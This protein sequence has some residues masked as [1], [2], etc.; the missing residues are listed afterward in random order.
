MNF[1]IRTVVH[2]SNVTH[3]PFVLKKILQLLCTVYWKIVDSPLFSKLY[4]KIKWKSKII[5]LNSPY[6]NV[7]GLGIGVG[8]RVEIQ[9]YMYSLLIPPRHCLAKKGRHTQH[10][11]VLKCWTK[12]MTTT[13]YIQLDWNQRLVVDNLDSEVFFNAIWYL[14]KYHRP[15]N[16][17]WSSCMGDL[18]QLDELD[19]VV[20]L[21]PMSNPYN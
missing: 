14:I 12:Y 4:R 1:D 2:V 5:V 17:L 15:M 7:T 9:T 13:Y 16:L 3:G 10:A 21:K 6:F 18:Q 11:K 8:W 20:F 19:N